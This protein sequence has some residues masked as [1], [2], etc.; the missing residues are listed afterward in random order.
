MNGSFQSTIMLLII[1]CNF[2]K[3]GL[4]SP[5]QPLQSHQG[6]VR[7]GK[8]RDRQLALRVPH[9]EVLR[10]EFI[11]SFPLCPWQSNVAGTG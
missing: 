1:C 10:A 6:I 3:L 5:G 7:Q 8:E 9:H 4:G 11:P 2:I